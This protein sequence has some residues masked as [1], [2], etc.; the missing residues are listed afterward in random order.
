[1]PGGIPGIV[2]DDENTV[3][4]GQHIDPLYRLPVCPGGHCLPEILSAALLLAALQVLQVL[5]SDDRDFGPW[6]FLHFPVDVVFPGAA[7]T[8]PALASGLRATD[9]VADGLRLGAVDRPVGIDQEFVLPDVHGQDFSFQD[10]FAGGFGVRNSDPKRRPSV[11]KRAA[12]EKFRAGLGEPMVEALVG[13]ERDDNGLALLEDGD[14]EDEIERALTWF[15]LGHEAGKPERALDA[16]F[17]GLFPRFRFGLPRGR[18]GLQG[19][20]EAVRAMTVGKASAR[21][22]VE[23]LG[24]EPS[25]ILPEGIDVPLGARPGFAEEGADPPL[26][27]VGRQPEGDLYGAF[28]RSGCLDRLDRRFGLFPA[29]PLPVE[30]RGEARQDRHEILHEVGELPEPF[31]LARQGRLVLGRGFTASRGRRVP[32]S[33]LEPRNGHEAPAR[34]RNDSRLSGIGMALGISEGPDQLGS[35]G[36]LY[37]ATHGHNVSYIGVLVKD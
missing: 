13:L 21:N 15:D 4:L 5:P 29:A 25:R 35:F 34:L 27:G 18:D 26:L 8:E 28:H 9:A 36:E 1:M 16:R 7:G 37:S 33:R 12:L 32:D 10:P 2:G 6:E 3:L 17:S 31:G 30:S 20:L 19:D 14:L 23:R 24:V 22:P 11:A